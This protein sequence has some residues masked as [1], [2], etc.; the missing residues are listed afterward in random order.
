MI[1]GSVELIGEKDGRARTGNIGAETGDSRQA[2]SFEHVRGRRRCRFQRNGG[3]VNPCLVHRLPAD[4]FQ[5]LKSNPIV[6]PYGFLRSI[7]CE[8]FIT[9]P[10][11]KA[12]MPFT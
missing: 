5:T 6:R 9:L 2:C 7:S 12:A 8:R 10:V 3:S 4:R 11:Q 1:D